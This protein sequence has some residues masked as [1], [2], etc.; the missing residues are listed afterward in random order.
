MHVS[1]EDE[2]EPVDRC[3]QLSQASRVSSFCATIAR[4]SRNVQ[5]PS[6]R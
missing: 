4:G 1:D 6:L 5:S 2:L 3:S